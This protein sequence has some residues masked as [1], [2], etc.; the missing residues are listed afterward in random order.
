RDEPSQLLLFVLGMGGA[1][2]MILLLWLNHK[3]VT[4]RRRKSAE[5]TSSRVRSC[6]VEAAPP[7]SSP[8][9]VALILSYVMGRAGPVEIATVN[10]IDGDLSTAPSTERADERPDDADSPQ[11]ADVSAALRLLDAAQLDRTR[12]SWIALMVYSGYAVGEIRALM[13]G[14]N[15]AIGH[16]VE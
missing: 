7:P 2:L 14:D 5:E 12:A 9:L 3:L 15:G 4:W 10:H 6:A 1:G 11:P 16:E 8:S 13:K